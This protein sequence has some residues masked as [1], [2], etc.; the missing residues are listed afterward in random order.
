MRN[1]FRKVKELASVSKD[2]SGRIYY[3]IGKFAKF[4]ATPRWAY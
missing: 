4:N 1:R 3:L 2:R